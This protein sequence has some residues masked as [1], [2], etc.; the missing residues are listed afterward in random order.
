VIICRGQCLEKISIA[1]HI[2]IE[3]GEEDIILIHGV[4]QIPTEETH[5][6][7]QI[8]TPTRCQDL[9]EG[10]QEEEDN[11]ILMDHCP[12]EVEDK[13]M[14]KVI[15]GITGGIIQEEGE[16]GIIKDMLDLKVR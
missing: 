14:Q 6:T 1:R 11:M 5:V 12:G 16:E 13:R 8:I 7:A 4:H 10:A 2:I 9:A 3:V 15:Q